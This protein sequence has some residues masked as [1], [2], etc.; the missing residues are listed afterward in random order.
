MM[1]VA[2]FRLPAVVTAALLLATSPAFAHHPTGGMMPTT[3]AH[4]LLSGIGHPIIGLD[5]LAFIIAVGLVAAL[6]GR[7]VLIPV[8]FLAGTLAGAGL[9]LASIALPA[10]ELVIAASVVLIGLVAMMG[11]RM[12]VL[13]T[14]SLV[15]L[16]GLFHGFAYAESIFGAET[17]PLVAYLIGFVAIQFAIAGTT[18]IIARKALSAG[19]SLTASPR[20]AGAMVAGAGVVLL[21]EHVKPL[22]LPVAG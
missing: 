7:L 15:A 8:L 10:T 2:K 5:H 13:A 14:G 6:A 11:A 9:H 16:A 12:S 4:G 17:T 22:L 18:A 20:F 3:F 1:S 19:G 21:A